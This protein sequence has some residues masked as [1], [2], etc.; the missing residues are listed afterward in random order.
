MNLG[1]EL[2]ACALREGTLTPFTEAGITREWLTDQEDTLRAA[3]FRQSEDMNAWLT[4]VRYQEQHGKVPSVDMFRRSYPEDAYKLPDTAYTAEELTS[5]FREDRREYLTRLAYEDIADAVRRGQVGRSAG[6]DGRD[7]LDRP[8]DERIPGHRA[9]LGQQG[10]RGR[11]EDRP[12]DHAR[13]PDG[14][15]GPG[16]PAGVLRLPAG[17]PD[18]LPRP[19]Q[20]GQDV[21]RP[22]VCADRVGRRQ[23]GAVRVVRDRGGQGPERA[24]HRR[25]AGLLRRGRST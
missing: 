8:R 13:H 2:V 17:Q 4:L 1:R 11:G 15:P 3:V 24:W 20:G 25:P 14:H 7:I 6:A 16:Q 10:L 5:I 23:A 18:L 9:G 22:A 12:E 21:V 19:G